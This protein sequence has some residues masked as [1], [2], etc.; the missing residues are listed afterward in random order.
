MGA[1]RASVPSVPTSWGR[2]CM[3]TFWSSEQRG[4][5]L[6]RRAPWG[7]RSGEDATIP[8]GGGPPAGGADAE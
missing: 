2:V 1:A 4:R 3:S 6:P 5:S 7:E 8:E